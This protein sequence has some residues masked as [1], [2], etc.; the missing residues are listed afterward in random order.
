MKLNNQFSRAIFLL[1]LIALSL[2]GGIAVAQQPARVRVPCSPFGTLDID[3]P[4]KDVRENKG[5]G[6]VTV[7]GRWRALNRALVS[8]VAAVNTVEIICYKPDRTCTE[9]LAKLYTR[10]DDPKWYK[11][12][13]GPV[14]LV[15]SSEFKVTEWTDGTIRAIRHAPVAD[16]E[17]TISIADKTAR[18][19]FQETNA[20][21]ATNANPVP[22]H[23]VLE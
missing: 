4:V 1:I 14:L 5:L 12:V 2:G 11:T 15:E 21:G 23:W 13:D 10:L 17:V 8:V 6:L 7:Q 19:T 20:R 22:Q 16:V 9:N 18:K 3:S